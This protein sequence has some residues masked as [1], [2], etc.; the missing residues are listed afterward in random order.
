MNSLRSPRPAGIAGA[1]RYIDS[2]SAVPALWGQGDA[3][4][5]NRF[6]RYHLY[7]DKM[8]MRIRPGESFLFA[9]K[10]PV[11]HEGIFLS[12]CPSA[13]AGRFAADH[14]RSGI[15]RDAFHIGKHNGAAIRNLSRINR[16]M[17]SP[18]ARSIPGGRLTGTFA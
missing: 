8:R 2:R 5:G 7:G 14:G 3:L 13:T 11:D 4:L 16:A 10:K 6:P 12:S 9:L 18:Q 17:T 15:D 1:R